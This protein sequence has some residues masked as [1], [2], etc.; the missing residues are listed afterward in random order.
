M[1]VNNNNLLLSTPIDT[2]T[3]FVISI[4]EINGNISRKPLQVKRKIFI[5][6]YENL[7]WKKT[8]LRNVQ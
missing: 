1:E 3:S 6:G 2:M 8:L 7:T 4:E 5:F